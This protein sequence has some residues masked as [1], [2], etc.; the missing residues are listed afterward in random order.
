MSNL[1][2][3]EA[4]CAMLEEALSIIRQQ[5]EIMAL[6]GIETVD[7]TLE[8][9]RTALLEKIEREGWSP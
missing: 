4:L 6:N 8:E 7:G 3:I 9:K 1:Q 5:A 2:M